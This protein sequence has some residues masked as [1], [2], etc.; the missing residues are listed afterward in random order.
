[1]KNYIHP[2]FNPSNLESYLL[3]V[4]RLRTLAQDPNTDIVEVSQNEYNILEDAANPT[5]KG[6]GHTVY[7]K[8][9]VIR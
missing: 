1:M 5:M 2:N 6:K 7:G 3:L 4:T 8:K 9:V